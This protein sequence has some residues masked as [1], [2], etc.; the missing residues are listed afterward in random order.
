MAHLR[1]Y[2]AT[3]DDRFLKSSHDLWTWITEG[4]N[5]Y[6]GGG[7][8]WKVGTDAESMGKGIPSNGPAAI[9]EPDLH[10]NTQMR[11]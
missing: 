3:N 6:D 7:I 8:Q 10:K 1:A 2:Y 9:I 4:W 5:D 11:P